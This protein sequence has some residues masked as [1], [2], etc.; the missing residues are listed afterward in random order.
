MRN[1]VYSAWVCGNYIVGFSIS[2][3]KRYRVRELISKYVSYFNLKK[4]K[5]WAWRWAC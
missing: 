5:S 2:G 1:K 4:Y 3:I